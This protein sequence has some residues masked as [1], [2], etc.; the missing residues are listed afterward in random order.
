MI[1]LA[2]AVSFL[3]GWE[4]RERGGD[5]GNNL[6]SEVGDEV[7]ALRRPS[8]SVIADFEADTSSFKS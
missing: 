1:L 6:E 2:G 5:N 8:V 4:Y 3:E 7:L